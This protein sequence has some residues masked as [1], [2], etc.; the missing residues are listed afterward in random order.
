MFLSI[1]IV[2]YN[3]FDLTCNCIRSIQDTTSIGHEIILIDN[4]SKDRSSEEFLK[5]FPGIRLFTLSENVGFGRA[6]NYGMERAIGKYILLLNSDT[7]IQ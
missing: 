4:N 5:L 1:I 2:N 7:G 3:T 6:N